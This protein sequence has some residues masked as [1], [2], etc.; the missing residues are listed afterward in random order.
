MADTAQKLSIE[1]I[2]SVLHDGDLDDVKDELETAWCYFDD[3]DPRSAGVS[4]ALDLA[5]T[6]VAARA[7]RC[8][9]RQ[10]ADAAALFELPGFTAPSDDEI[11]ALI[12]D[13]KE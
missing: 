12:L 13:T 6:E 7:A 8:A 4:K 2:L 9:A 3:A 1:R 11:L 5:R 10:I